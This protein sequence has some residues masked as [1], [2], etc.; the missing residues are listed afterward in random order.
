MRGASCLVILLIANCSPVSDDPV[1]KKSLLD[2]DQAGENRRLDAADYDSSQYANM[3]IHLN[4]DNSLAALPAEKGTFLTSLAG[5]AIAYWQKALLVRPA[6]GN[7]TL[8]P[9]CEAAWGD[10][11]ECAGYLAEERCG[12]PDGPLILASHK[13]GGLKYCPQCAEGADCPLDE[14][15][16]PSNCFTTAAGAGVAADYILYIMA[17][18]TAGCGGATLAYAGKCHTDQFDRPIAGRA[19]FCPS[20]ISA[21]ETDYAEQFAT[22]VHEI[23]HALGFSSDSLAYFRDSKTGAPLTPRDANGEPVRTPGNFTCPSGLVVTNPILPANNTLQFFEERGLVVSKLVTPRMLSVARNY[24]DCPSLNGVEWEN[25]PTSAGS[26]IG[27]HWEERLF[28]QELMTSLSQDRTMYSALTLAF[29]EDTGWYRAN[30]AMAGKHD[31]WGYRQG[32]PFATE[33][34]LS[35]NET[36]GG[37]TAVGHPFCTSKEEQGCSADYISRGTC[38]TNSYALDAV[39]QRLQ[40]HQLI[41]ICVI[42]NCCLPISALGS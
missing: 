24:F 30:Y 25:Q 19:N 3:R 27:S 28:E 6:T 32:C 14:R 34:C 12:G 7:L 11:L 13:Q 21:A 4:F 41:Q 33:K 16:I 31:G 2:Y 37:V 20:S 9:T 8:Q 15:G 40:V 36:S 29:F 1:I 38:S 26:C 5:E 18:E 23:G 42:T 10:N 17:K 39:S 35:K 22:A